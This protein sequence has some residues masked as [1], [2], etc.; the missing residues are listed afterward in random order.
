MRGGQP[1]GRG[2]GANAMAVA[3]PPAP[4]YACGMSAGP[5]AIDLL[6][7]LFQAHP[8]HGVPARARVAEAFN[9]FVE[10]VPTDT[11]KYELDKDSGHLRADRPQRFS[12]VCPTLYGF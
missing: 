12:S 5:T 10:M 8:W 2:P 7:S 6:R 4:P 11:V 3:L 9:V 1:S